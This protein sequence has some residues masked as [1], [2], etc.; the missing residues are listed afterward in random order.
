MRKGELQRALAIDARCQGAHFALGFIAWTT[1]DLETAE[2][3]FRQEPTVDSREDLPYYYLAK[4]LGGVEGK[5]DE[6]L[7]V[8]K[9]QK[10]GKERRMSIRARTDRLEGKVAIVTGGAGPGIGHGISTV[11]AH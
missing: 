2:G 7:A 3:E 4:T 8:L 10:P 9:Q 11:L 6:A 5:L 1:R